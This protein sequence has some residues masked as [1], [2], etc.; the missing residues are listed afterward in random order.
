LGSVVSAISIALRW[1]DALPEDG[2]AADGGPSATRA[3]EAQ[4]TTAINTTTVSQ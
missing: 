2:A 4:P 1:A 3:G